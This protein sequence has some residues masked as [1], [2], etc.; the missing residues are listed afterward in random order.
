M[1]QPKIDIESPQQDDLK[2]LFTELKTSLTRMSSSDMIDYQLTVDVSAVGATSFV[3]RVDGKPVATGALVRHTGSVAEAKRLF[4]EPAFRKHGIGRAIL[5]HI[6]S[7]AKS[8][9]FKE[10]Y[11]VTDAELKESI[12]FCEHAGFERTETFLNHKPS[13]QSVFFRKAL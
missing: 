11:I 9:G 1:V 8:E 3:A 13:K 4:T 7:L 5:R 12:A 2:A 6:S 10:L